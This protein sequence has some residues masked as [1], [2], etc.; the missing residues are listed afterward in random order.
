MREPPAM[1]VK[2]GDG[3]LLAQLR[4]AAFE[5]VVHSAFQRAVNI[6]C[7]TDGRLY[8][9]VTA[10]M[11]DGPGTLV[12]ETDDFLGAQ[13]AVGDRVT[14]WN[15][16][17]FISRR[18]VVS[19]GRALQWSMP[20]PGAFCEDAALRRR[21][22][23]A[24]AFILRH[25]MPGGFLENSNAS[26]AA[27]I[28][29][30]MLQE[31][32]WALLRAFAEDDEA[33]A[34]RHAARLLGLGPGLTPS[35]DDFLLGLL[36]ARGLRL[37]ARGGFGRAVTAMARTATNEI[38]YAALER[39]ALGEVRDRIACLLVALCG[40]QDELSNAALMGVIT[41]GSCSGTDIALGVVHGLQSTL[42]HGEWNHADQ[43]RD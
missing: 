22:R 15:G 6:A 24:E 14:G 13:I 34:L 36:A 27:R 19:V 37:G 33:R 10:D 18:A 43:D 28:A 17:I 4:G 12:V 3:A 23:A 31:E 42:G 29:T 9:L 41:I 5:G 21:L 40:V 7:T 32:G 26:P 39:A 30:R 2:S 25:G 16:G 35:G 20:R 8:A 11:D 38:S 1:Q